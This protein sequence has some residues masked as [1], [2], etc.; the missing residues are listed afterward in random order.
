MSGLPRGPWHRKRLRSPGLRTA[1]RPARKGGQWTDKYLLKR[2]VI[3]LF[4]RHDFRSPEVV[5]EPDVGYVQLSKEPVVAG[6]PGFHLGVP[7]EQ[8]MLREV[9][10]CLVHLKDRGEVNSSRGRRS[11]SPLLRRSDSSICRSDRVSSVRDP[12]FFFLGK[13]ET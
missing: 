12:D 1:E 4:G 13:T 11:S 8:R 3:I 10:F 2:D 5:Q 7:D 9:P 6:G